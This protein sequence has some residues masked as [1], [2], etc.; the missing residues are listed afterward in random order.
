MSG[1]L[2]GVSLKQRTGRPPAVIVV[3]A[4]WPTQLLTINTS[5][6]QP[7]VHRLF[8]DMHLSVP[9]TSNLKVV[10]RD[11]ILGSSMLFRVHASHS[12]P[13]TCFDLIC[14]FSWK[15]DGRSFSSTDLEIMARGGLSADAG[16]EPST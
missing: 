14:Q 10:F 15:L 3:T 6:P 16:Q 4:F 13:C 7:Y 9:P 11:S 5:K 1:C 8:A 12:T 2:A